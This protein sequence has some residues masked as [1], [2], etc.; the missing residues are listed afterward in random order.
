MALTVASCQ[1]VRGI[2]WSKLD[3]ILLDMDGTLL[4]LEFDNHFW[5]TVIPAEWGRQRGLDI[6]TSQEIL[7]PLFAEQQGRLNWYCLDFWG[8]TL[9]L[10]IPHIKSAHAHGISW[11]PQAKRF[12][13]HLRASH[14]DIVMITNAHPLT[15]DMKAERLL[16]AQW[17][18]IMISSHHYDTPKETPVF[19]NRLMGERPFDPE[20]TLFIDDS[21]Y[22]LDAAEAYGI[23]HLITLRQPDSTVPPRQTTRY[24]AIHHFDEII[25]GLPTID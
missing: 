20:R 13:Q 3:T 18:D 23:A 14:L 15:L 12:M 16:L 4:D 24:P 25:N 2:D 5:G 10:D 8:K 17:F 21:E 22:V 11:R 6:A 7:A 19:W 9:D 1:S